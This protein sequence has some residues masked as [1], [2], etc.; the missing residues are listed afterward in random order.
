MSET[1]PALFTFVKLTV[2]DIDAATTF[3]EKGFDLTH[4][5]TVDTP[6]FR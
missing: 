5:D 3:F 6:T 1:T 2:T 4:A